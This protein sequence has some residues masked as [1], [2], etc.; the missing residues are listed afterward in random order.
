MFQSTKMICPECD[1]AGFVCTGALGANDP[2]TVEMQ[3]WECGG[4]G[5]L[6]MEADDDAEEE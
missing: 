5:E 4:D 1:G 2:N 6:Y 3:C